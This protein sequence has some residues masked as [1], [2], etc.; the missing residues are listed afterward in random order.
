MCSLD[1]SEKKMGVRQR[2][3]TESNI[4]T[5]LWGLPTCHF[6]YSMNYS[7]EL[8]TPS[9]TL[10]DMVG[11]KGLRHCEKEEGRENLS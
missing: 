10:W 7:I 2:L 5:S 8:Q 1:G 11:R 6:V 9:E 4:L 3:N